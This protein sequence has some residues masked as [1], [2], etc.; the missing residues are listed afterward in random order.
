MSEQFEHTF[1]YTDKADFIRQLDEMLTKLFSGWSQLRPYDEV[2]AAYP[3]LSPV[4]FSMRLNRFKGE[5][6]KKMG[7]SGKRTISLYVTRE[8]HDHLQK[9]APE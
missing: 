5:F 2:R 1:R 3:H 8:L 6:P 7:P 9:G 4:A